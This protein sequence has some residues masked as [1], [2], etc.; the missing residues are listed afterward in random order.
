MNVFLS[1]GSN[2]GDRFELLRAAVRALRR[3]HD[4]HVVT[5]S[6]IYE[7]EPWESEPGLLRDEQRWYLNCVVQIETSLPAEILLERLKRLE[8][9]LGRSRAPGT[10]EAQR[11]AART[12]DADILFYG[13]RVISAPDDLHIPHLLLHERAFVLRPLADVA[14]ELEHPTLYRTVREL[15]EELGDDHE[16]RPSGLPRRWFED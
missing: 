4:V 9:D 14:P 1:L 7:T 16:V 8:T 12:L 10:P 5:A 3:M 15:L 6:A 11:F 2:L 13:Q